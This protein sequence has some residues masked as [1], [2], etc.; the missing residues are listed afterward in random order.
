MFEIKYEHVPR[1]R[2]TGTYYAAT[3][4]SIL[5]WREFLKRIPL[6]RVGAVCSGGEVGF[7]SI[8]PLVRTELVLVDNS[9]AALQVAMFKYLLLRD[10]GPRKAHELLSSG[11]VQE[12]KSEFNKVKGE[13]PLKEPSWSSLLDQY[14]CRNITREWK[15]VSADLV[16]KACKKLDKVKFVHGSFTDLVDKGPFSLVYLSNALGY[17]G[18]D[19][20][21]QIALVEKSLRPGGYVILT[22]GK[23]PKHW[24]LL[25]SETAGYG[26]CSISWQH[27]LYRIPASKVAEAA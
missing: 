5:R 18:E 16:N 10:L 2:N 8:L 20:K 1:C 17:G 23:A 3:N 15:R 4:E 24:E 22:D 21:A 7:L 27:E 26:E 13:I 14:Y 19:I 25:R 11:T 9:Y 6:Y 12:F